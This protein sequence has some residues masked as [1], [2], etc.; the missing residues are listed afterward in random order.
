MNNFN[1]D[2][3]A[4]KSSFTTVWSNVAYLSRVRALPT[5]YNDTRTLI[6]LSSLDIAFDTN[7][8]TELEEAL[9]SVVDSYKSR[10]LMDQTA[11][12]SLNLAVRRCDFNEI[13]NLLHSIKVSNDYAEFSENYDFAF[14]DDLFNKLLKDVN[15]DSL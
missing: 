3:W 11:L 6:Y 14:P 13:C 8:V 2:K 12:N 15:N 1:W 7:S 5:C 4:G 9:R 10:L